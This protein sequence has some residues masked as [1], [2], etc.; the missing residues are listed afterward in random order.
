MY[1][2]RVSGLYFRID[3]FFSTELMTSQCSA[4][5]FVFN[6]FLKVKH[7]VHIS[8]KVRMTQNKNMIIVCQN[9]LGPETDPSLLE[10]VI[11]S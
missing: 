7:T 4:L 5:S 3:N 9:L 6:I 2:T 11:R 1:S 8:N 10:L